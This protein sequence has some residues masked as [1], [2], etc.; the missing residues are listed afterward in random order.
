MI[1]FSRLDKIIHERASL[2]IM[3]LLAAPPGMVVPG[4]EN[5][6]ENE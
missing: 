3:T 6:I 4:P 2:S 1:D 5:R